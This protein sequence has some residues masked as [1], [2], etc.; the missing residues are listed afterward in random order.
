M[1][2]LFSAEH[3]RA[4]ARTM[5]LS[6]SVG[7]SLIL[8]GPTA[9]AATNETPSQLVASVY[10]AATAAGSFHYIDQQTLGINGASVHQTESGDVGRG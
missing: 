3:L 6:G 5:F 10:A 9:T 2:S 7:V 8:P 4:A 1:R